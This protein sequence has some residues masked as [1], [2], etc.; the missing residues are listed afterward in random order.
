MRPRKPVC[1]RC[2]K[3]LRPFHNGAY[4]IETFSD[5]RLIYKIWHCDIYFCPKCK[6]K[7]VYGFGDNPI[8]TNADGQEEC[9]KFVKGLKEDGEFLAYDY[10]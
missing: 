6:F 4:L 9:A 7:I 3:T 1:V 8:M 10:E 5:N 2:K